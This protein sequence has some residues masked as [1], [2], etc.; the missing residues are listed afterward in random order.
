[1]L[2]LVLSELSLL[3]KYEKLLKS[4]TCIHVT[5]RKCLKADNSTS[6]VFSCWVFEGFYELRMFLRK[7]V[8]LLIK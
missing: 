6:F 5:E 3:L 8:I 2:I 1:M 7:P 4:E